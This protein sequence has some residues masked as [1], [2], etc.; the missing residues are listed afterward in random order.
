MYSILGAATAIKI[1]LYLYCVAFRDISDSMMAR[2]SRVAGNADADA[3]TCYGPGQPCCRCLYIKLITEDQTVLRSS[4][5][6]WSALHALACCLR[7]AGGVHKAGHQVNVVRQVK[8]S[9]L[10]MQAL[11]EDHMNDI[12]S[13]AGAIACGIGASLSRKV[14]WIDPVGAIVISLYIIFSWLSILTGQVC[15]PVCCQ[16]LAA[17]W[18]SKRKGRQ[19]I[20][21]HGHSHG[22]LIYS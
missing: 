16:L 15:H 5:P 2:P 6:R 13:N 20:H 19:S 10:G 22:Q 9:L 8:D 17:S 3:C 18:H 14:W 11:S 4:S 7:D 12:L 1:A 21:E